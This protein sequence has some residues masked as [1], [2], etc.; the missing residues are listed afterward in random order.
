MLNPFV[1]VELATTNVPKAKAFYKR[2]F[3]W[4]LTDLPMPATGGA[5]A[6]IDVGDGTGGRDDAADGSR[7]AVGVDALCAREGHRCGHKEGGKKF[8]P[9]L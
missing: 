3:K 7:S 1:H 8:A 2:L 5:Y 6:M 4:K 9:K